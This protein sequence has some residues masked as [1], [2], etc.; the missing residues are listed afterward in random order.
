MYFQIIKNGLQPLHCIYSFR[1]RIIK[2]IVLHEASSWC[3][4]VVRR[5]GA[6][7]ESMR[8]IDPSKDLTGPLVEFGPIDGDCVNWNYNWT[9]VLSEVPWK[10]T[11]F[12]DTPSLA[13]M[14]TCWG[15]WNTLKTWMDGSPLRSWQKLVKRRTL[16]SSWP[17]AI[18]EFVSPCLHGPI[19]CGTICHHIIGVEPA[20]SHF[21]ARAASMFAS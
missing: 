14:H 13:S 2:S 12:D 11:C 21:I 3:I 8:T 20:C 17:V 6:S 10:G 4:I 19:T 5:L 1:R 16:K 9:E 18:C 15:E 7:F